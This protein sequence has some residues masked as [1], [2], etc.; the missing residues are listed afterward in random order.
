ME[1][2]VDECKLNKTL[3]PNLRVGAH[4]NAPLQII[5]WLRHLLEFVL[6]ELRSL[7][8]SPEGKEGLKNG[9]THVINLVLDLVE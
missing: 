4:C 1:I 8:N 2:R 6:F 5:D 7:R 3:K 9:S